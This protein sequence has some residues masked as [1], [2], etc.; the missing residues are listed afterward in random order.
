MT[1]TVTWSIARSLAEFSA[2][3]VN[4]LE[5]LDA[6]A[7][8]ASPFQRHWLRRAIDGEASGFLH[9]AISVGG[10][11]EA[12]GFAVESFAF[13][14]R[15]KGPRTLTFPKGPVLRNSQHID[16]CLGAIGSAARAL[17]ASIIAIEPQLDGSGVGE[18]DRIAAA[19]GWRAETTGTPA[20]TMRLDLTLDERELYARMRPNTKRLM[21]RAES[22]GIAVREMRDD[23]DA[24]ALAAI[25]AATSTRKGFDALGADTF[26]AMCREL[27]TRPRAGQVL[28]AE[29]DGS[30]AGGIVIVR[31]GLGAHYVYGATDPSGGRRNLPIAYPLQRHAIAWARRQGCSFYDLGGYDPSSQGGVA[32]FKRGLRGDVV[33]F[34]PM[35]TIC[36]TPAAAAARQV[37]R[38]ARGSLPW[39]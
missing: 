11:L 36:L 18:F 26:A 35:H 8:A 9:V 17:H 38:V 2:E 5:E 22:Y 13:G 20:M 6:E 24:D 37:A 21:L 15:F 28:L 27:V 4:A 12:A 16:A 30:V 14:R 34:P 33:A 29:H 23:N 3:R 7:A 32:L 25:H 1:T 31:A 39:R 19:L 10:R